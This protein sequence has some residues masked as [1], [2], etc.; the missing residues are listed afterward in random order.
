MKKIQVL[1]CTLRDG[2]YVNNWQFGEKAV[3]DIRYSLE[4]VGVE[5]I[6][7]GF[8]REEPN[9][10]GRSVYDRMERVSET[11]LERQPDTIYGA[12]I[13]MANYVAPE[14]I[15]FR[16]DKEPQAIRYPYWKRC[17]DEAYEYC[18]RIKERGYL[19]CCQPTRAEQYS[20]KDFAEM[21]QRFS[22]LAPYAVYIVDTFGLLQKDDVLRLA[23]VAHET[24]P[25]DIILGYHAHDNMGQAFHNACAFLEMDLGTRTLQVDASICGMGR[26]AGNLKLEL[27]LEYL[28]ANWGKHY[29]LGPV[30]EMWDKY[31]RHIMREIPWGYHPGYF[32]TA[33]NR[34]NPNYAHYYVEKGLSAAEIEK[35]VSRMEG[36]DK[37]LYS[38]EKAKRYANLR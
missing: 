23:H 32:I 29:Q 17:L 26:G 16:S 38:P 9:L 22:K 11:L 18:A 10:P 14:K 5:F 37:Y 1:D 8:V 25:A 13:E 6:E 31:L 33:K 7:L 21:C 12:M 24:L 35:A 15:C 28:N 34:C 36:E 3:S 4:K 30:Y 19:L 20:E 27:I 2:G